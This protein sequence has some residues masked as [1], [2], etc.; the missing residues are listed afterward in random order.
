MSEINE[1][2]IFDQRH[3]DA[4]EKKMTEKRAEIDILTSLQTRSESEYQTIRTQ[5][6]KAKREIKKIIE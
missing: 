6:L 1:P 5:Y 4:L 2:I 3:L